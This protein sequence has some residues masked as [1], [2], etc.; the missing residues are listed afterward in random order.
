MPWHPVFAAIS[1]HLCMSISHSTPL[2]HSIPKNYPSAAQPLRGALLFCP[3]VGVYP[4]SMSL[5]VIGW[6][7]G[8]MP[9]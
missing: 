3:P 1:P 4:R 5:C 6:C 2:N 7:G 9:R 8:Y